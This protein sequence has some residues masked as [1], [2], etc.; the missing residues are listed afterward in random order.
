MGHAMVM[1]R[2]KEYEREMARVSE[3]VRL[4]HE[5]HGLLA[6]VLPLDYGGGMQSV[7][8]CY[9]PR[10]LYDT[11]QATIA[12]MALRAYPKGTPLYALRENG[13]IVGLQALECDGG[14]VWLRDEVLEKALA[15]DTKAPS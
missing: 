4:D 5:D 12:Y 15:L 3:D 2:G 8:L 9:S 7:A 10:F 11:A 6:V 14:A 13:I 1:V